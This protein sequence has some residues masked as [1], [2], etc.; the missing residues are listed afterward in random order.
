[1]CGTITRTII[2]AAPSTPMVTPSSSGSSSAISVMVARKVRLAVT[3][4]TTEV[5]L[6]SRSR[7]VSALTRDIRSPG[8]CSSSAGICSRT[9]LE[10]N[11]CRATSTT[12]SAVRSSRNDPSAPSP[13]LASTSTVISTNSPVMPRFADSPLIRSRT[14]N[15]SAN[16]AADVA[17]L[18]TAPPSSANR[19]GRM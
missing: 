6:T 5:V 3:A 12:D 18:N 7:V 10:T 11:R 1:M 13:A 15:G 19:N 17:R 4:E 9:N 8:S 16:P 14:T 2:W